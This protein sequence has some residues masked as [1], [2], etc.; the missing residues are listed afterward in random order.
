MQ[1]AVRAS[2]TVGRLGGDEFAL[3]LNDSHVEDYLAVLQRVIE[4]INQPIVLN[5]QR[6]VKV[7]ASI[8]VAFYPKNG[9]NVDTLLQCA[10]NAMYQAKQSG[11]NRVCVFDE[12]V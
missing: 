5:N 12:L 7:G 9:D 6:V 8:G 4:I 1:A 3:L 10:D 2:D 11:K